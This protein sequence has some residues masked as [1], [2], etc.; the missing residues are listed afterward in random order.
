MR[1]LVAFAVGALL[2]S[3][4]L[5]R[6][7]AASP[8]DDLIAPKGGNSACFSR[9]Y[10]ADHLRKNPRQKITAM[11][12]WLGYAPDVKG[13]PDLGIA[14]SRRG[15]SDPLFAQGGCVWDERAN[16]DTSDRRM[17]SEFKKEAGAG[18]MMLARPDV[19]DVSSAE[20]GGFLILD[21]GKDKNTMLV[22]PGA[23]LVMVK[24]IDLAKQLDIDFGIEDRVFLLSRAD[25]KVCDFLNQALSRKRPGGVDHE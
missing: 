11:T 20:E 16:R 17:I 25:A 4:S 12:V 15:D 2:A 14:I 19:F 7:Q 8:L 22:Y 3:I 6:V 21:R 23:G 24:R 1:R 9:V 10:D 18:C 5:A 13:G